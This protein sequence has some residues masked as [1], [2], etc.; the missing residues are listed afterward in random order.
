VSADEFA[1]DLPLILAAMDQPS[2][3][4]INTW[5]VS[6][7]TRELGLKVAISGTGGDEL[8]GGY[9]SFR[10]LP[11][12]SRSLA[13][14]SHIPGFAAI[15]RIALRLALATGIPINPKHAGLL[16]YGGHIAGGYL[17]QRGL[18]LPLELID[19]LGDRELL[20]AGLAELSP[21]E[22]LRNMLEAGPRT[23]FGKIA[24]LE[25]GFYLRNQLL[26]DSDWASMAH[27]LE[28]R[29][30]LVDYTLL[31]KVA[32]VMLGESRRYG[33]LLLAMAP[34]KPLPPYIVD[35]PKTG[36]GIPIERWLA[37]RLPDVVAPARVGQ[38]FSRRWARYVASAHGALA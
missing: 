18:F 37:K 14:P 11:W 5:F 12:L 3:D 33:K 2:V 7:A 17:L 24:A 38:P 9:R 1:H 25:S 16:H 26:R 22:L 4:G 28:L 35:R 23:P 8:F 13:V 27:S 31:G 20:R 21:L 29:T 30:P 6:K 36:F 15:W 19:A 10:Q 32:P 34:Q